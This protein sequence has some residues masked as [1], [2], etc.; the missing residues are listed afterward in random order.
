MDSSSRRRYHWPG[1]FHHVFP[2]CG[3]Y[4]RAQISEYSEWNGRWVTPGPEAKRLS[5]HELVAKVREGNPDVP[6]AV[7][8][9]KSD[10][11]A[12]LIIN[13][14]HEN[15]VFVD[16]YSGELLGGLSATHNLQ[17]LSIG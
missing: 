6:P 14:G 11:T 7:I 13:L 2:R 5:L 15:T 10:P 4:V 16:S 17:G 1:D 9:V 3:A 12:F 8:T